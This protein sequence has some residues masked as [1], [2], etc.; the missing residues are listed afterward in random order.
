MLLQAARIFPYRA[1]RRGLMPQSGGA[2]HPAGLLEDGCATPVNE[3]SLFHFFSPSQ[4][5][6]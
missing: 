6:F 4:R 3:E 1:A 5:R 2:N